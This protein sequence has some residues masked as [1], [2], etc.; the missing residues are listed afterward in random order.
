VARCE[1]LSLAGDVNIP[2]SPP[3]A[4]AGGKNE[5]RN[6]VRLVSRRS[7]QIAV[8]VWEGVRTCSA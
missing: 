6:A 7:N 4:E 8:C 1:L 3:I 2:W 5:R